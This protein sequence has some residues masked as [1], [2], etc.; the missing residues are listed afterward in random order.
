MADVPVVEAGTL[1]GAGQTTGYYG[2][3]FRPRLRLTSS[4][5]RGWKRWAVQCSQQGEILRRFARRVSVPCG[6]TYFAQLVDHDISLDRVPLAQAHAWIPEEIPNRRTPWL[7]LDHV[8]AAAP[9][10]AAAL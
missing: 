8:Y 4:M 7:D 3:M 9:G 10:I 5:S 2:R 1:H 6:Y